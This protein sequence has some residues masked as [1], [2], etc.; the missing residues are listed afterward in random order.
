M[1][2]NPKPKFYFFVAICVVITISMIV[3]YYY[4]YISAAK[5]NPEARINYTALEID[6]L[7]GQ[8]DSLRVTNETWRW[9]HVVWYSEE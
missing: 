8:F 3:L 6:K 5:P 2:K 1:R 7:L 4:L 9:Y